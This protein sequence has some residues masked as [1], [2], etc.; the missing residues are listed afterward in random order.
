MT[1]S[2]ART[3]AVNLDAASSQCLGPGIAPGES[4]DRVSRGEQLADDGGPDES[5]GTCDEDTHCR[6]PGVGEGVIV[7]SAARKFE[8]VYGYGH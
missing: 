1:P 6:P 2:E 8:D 3:P 7:G 5:C 4:E